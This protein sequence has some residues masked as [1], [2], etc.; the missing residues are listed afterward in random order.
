MIGGG[1][2]NK[3]KTNF[4]LCCKGDD[5]RIYEDSIFPAYVSEKNK[6]ITPCH[7]HLKNMTFFIW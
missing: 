5:S 1:V 3:L 2:E 4:D 7:D 6:I